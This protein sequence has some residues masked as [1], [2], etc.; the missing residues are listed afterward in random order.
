VILMLFA[1]A[2]LV[3]IEKAIKSTG[4]GG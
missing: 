3:A 2:A 1:D 4:V